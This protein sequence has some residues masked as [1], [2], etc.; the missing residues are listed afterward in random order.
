[1]S[2][3]TDIQYRRN[4]L[5]IKGLRPSSLVLITNRRTMHHILTDSCLDEKLIKNSS[6]TKEFYGMKVIIIK[7]DNFYHNNDL[8]FEIYELINDDR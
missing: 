3:F 6:S 2:I 1:M 7:S 4:Q 8:H 5:I